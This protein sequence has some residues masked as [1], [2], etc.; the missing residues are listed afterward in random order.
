M[1]L[2]AS[3]HELSKDFARESRQSIT[4]NFATFQKKVCSKLLKN[5]VNPEELRLFVINQFPPGDCIPPSPAS[6]FDIFEA[7]TRHGLW[8]CL[9]YSPLVQIIHAFADNDPEMEG[10]VQSYEKDLKAYCIVTT[11]EDYI[12]VELGIVEFPQAKRADC[13]LDVAKPSPAK[14]AKYDVNVADPP[15]ERARHN[16]HYYCPLEWK[17]KFIDHSLQYLRDVWKRFSSR[18]LIPESPPTAL[19]DR[20]RKGCFSV[21]WLIPSGLILPFLERLRTDT[22]FFQQYRILRVTV[23]DQC[24]YEEVSEKMT[25]VSSY[26]A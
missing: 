25:P 24:V 6:V 15:A 9:H 5:G 1:Y 18:Y 21:T 8:D 19:L 12:D 10:W 4:A 14:R 7:I 20:V 23:R 22:E 16:P 13:D 2:D 17:T 11:V 3:T 26:Q